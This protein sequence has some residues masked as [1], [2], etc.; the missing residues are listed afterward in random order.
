MTLPGMQDDVYDYYRT[1]TS[2]EPHTNLSALLL[3]HCHFLF[4]HFPRIFHPR[5]TLSTVYGSASV[6]HVRL[7]FPFASEFIPP[8]LQ[9]NNPP[10]P[11]FGLQKLGT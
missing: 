10:S 6:K 2:Q 3:H 9:R 1:H 4:L 11:P 5:F 7:G 8:F